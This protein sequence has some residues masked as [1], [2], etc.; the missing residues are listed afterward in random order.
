MRRRPLM[1]RRHGTL[2]ESATARHV[3]VLA[4]R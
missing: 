4:G 2:A 3:A 1:E